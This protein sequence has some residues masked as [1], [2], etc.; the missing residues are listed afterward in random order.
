MGVL[1][2][3]PDSFSDGGD[4]LDADAA[5]TRGLALA[6]E[7]AD[8]VDVGGE[9]TRPGAGRIDLD[10]ELARV[11]PVV[12]RLAAAGVA[13]SVDT[14]RSEVAAAAVAAGAVLVNDVSGGLADEQMLATVA[15]LDCAYLAM[16]WR[17]HSAEMQQ[18]AVYQDVVAEVI[19]ELSDRVAAAKAAGIKASRLVIDPGLGF[20]KTVEQN[21]TLLRELDQFDRLGLPILVGTSRKRFLGELLADADGARPPKERDDATTALTALLAATG[22]WGVRTHTVRPQLDA[23][24]VAGMWQRR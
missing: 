24:L 1:N 10:A 9:S 5:V 19:A 15:D 23:I 3:T 11:L 2:V 4:F 20:A 17:G 8:L 18:R 6:A 7:G 22:V 12:E 16:H 13:V 21:W 14:T